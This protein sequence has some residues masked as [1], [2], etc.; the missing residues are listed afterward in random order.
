MTITSLRFTRGQPRERR[1]IFSSSSRVV[2]FI[3]GSNFYRGCVQCAGRH[4]VDLV[5]LCQKFAAGR[6]LSAVR[7]YNASLPFSAPGA[8]EQ[9][10]F[11]ARLR[12]SGITVI[13]G[14]LEKRTRGSMVSLVEKGIDVAIAV[15]M[16]MLA[17]SDAYDV[18]V[19][20]SGDADFVR[21]V[22]AVK[23]LGKRVENAYFSRGGSRHLK[24]V[25][26]RQIILDADFLRECWRG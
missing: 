21:A 20:V 5:R 14:K 7:Y 17:F 1:R 13:L 6:T 8:V 24:Q 9:Q 16:L 10:K 22:D 2:V 19:L 18:A 3:D 12:S 15:D 4:D 26:D 11:L 23:Q 25:A